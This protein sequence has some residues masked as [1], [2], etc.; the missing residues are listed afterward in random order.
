MGQVKR[1]GRELEREKKSARGEGRGVKGGQKGGWVRLVGLLEVGNG[2]CFEKK[3][4]LEQRVN[5]AGNFSRNVAFPLFWRERNLFSIPH[6][7]PFDSFGKW[8][9]EI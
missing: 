6:S 3:R 1:A 2:L 7:P 8:K 9:K 5:L 4:T